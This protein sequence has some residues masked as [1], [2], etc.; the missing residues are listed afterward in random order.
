MTSSGTHSNSIAEGSMRVDTRYTQALMAS[1]GRGSYPGPTCV[2]GQNII[3][4]TRPPRE[5][6]LGNV[7]MLAESFK[8]FVEFR[9]KLL[10]RFL[11][12]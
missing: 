8:L 12:L 5:T 7:M 2:D 11:R 9:N 6:Y 3:R 4:V 1:G 10:V